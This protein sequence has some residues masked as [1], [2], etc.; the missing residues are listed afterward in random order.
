MLRANAVAQ[1]FL[2]FRANELQTAQKLA[3]AS[4]NQQ[5]AQIKQNISSLTEQIAGCQASLRPPHS[6]RN[7]AACGQNKTQATT[8]LT[9]L[10]QAV[11][12]EQT[13][14]QP[15]TTAAAKGSV[16]LDAAAPLP[17]SRLKPLLL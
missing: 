12:N 1:A 15:A 3:L 2:Q 10:E 7:L 8:T 14:T 6:S 11:I 5:I 4:L 16:V 13:N 9:N 17:H